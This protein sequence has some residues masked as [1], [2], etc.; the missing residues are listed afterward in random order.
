MT[1]EQREEC[2]HEHAGATG[3]RHHGPSS[4]WMH[5]PK[6]VLAQIPLKPGHVFVDLGCGAGD[7]AIEAARI[8]GP[9]GRVVA[10]DKWPYLLDNLSKASQSAGLDNITPL[11]ADMTEPLPMENNSV[12]VIFI[13]TVLHIFDLNKI[14]PDLFRE[15]FRILKPGGCLAIVECKKRESDF[16]PPLHLRKSPE[17]IENAVLPHGFERLGYGDLGHNYL[18]QFIRR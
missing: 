2:R 3:R 9:G 7:Y 18:I 4:A 11:L 6:S 1:V 12:D 10:M 14:G 17:D 13:A 16:G 15:V 5:E 8:V